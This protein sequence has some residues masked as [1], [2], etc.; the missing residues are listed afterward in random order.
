MGK[1]GTDLFSLKGKDN[2]VTVYY[3][4]N[5]FEVDRL[6]NTSSQF[7]IRKL[8][9]HFEI[10]GSPT[11]VVSDNGP[12]Y[13]SAVFQHFASEWD[14]EHLCSSPGNGRANGKAKSAVKTANASS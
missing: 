10:Y 12:Q 13:T 14:F 8:K 7:V 11:K 1:I 5:P 6:E 3:Y 9:A 4:S 2:M